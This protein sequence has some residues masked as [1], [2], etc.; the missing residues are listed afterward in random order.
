[1]TSEHCI[2][3]DAEVP[4]NWA[5]R[6]SAS[7]GIQCTPSNREDLRA[8]TLRLMVNPSLGRDLRTPDSRDEGAAWAVV[9]LGLFYLFALAQAL[10]EAKFEIPRNKRRGLRV[11]CPRVKEKGGRGL[12]GPGVF[13]RLPR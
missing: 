11:S 8:G 9:A 4:L 5:R 3:D 6:L 2:G 7:R 1:M 10:T 13:P 12:E